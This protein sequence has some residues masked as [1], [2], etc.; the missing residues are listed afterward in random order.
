MASNPGTLTVKVPGVPFPIEFQD[1]VHDR[2]FATC[3]FFNGDTTALPVF[4]GDPGGAIPGGARALTQADSNLQRN[5]LNGLPPG[6]EALIYSIQAEIKCVG[7]SANGTSGLLTDPRS[8]PAAQQT[9]NLFDLMFMQV[10]Y[11]NKSVSEGRLHRY[12]AGGGINLVS[13]VTGQELATNGR[14]SPRDQMALVLPVW[15]KPGISFSVTVAP[16][17]AITVNQ[18]FANGQ[19]AQTADYAEIQVTKEGLIRRP[20]T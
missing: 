17:A 5:G 8:F 19:V 2:I 3:E 11:N 16:V 13:V 7:D 6:W 1:W 14:M 9:F 4:A 15:Y 20:V 12:P 18:P 10:R